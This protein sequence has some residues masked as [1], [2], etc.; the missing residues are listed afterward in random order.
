MTFLYLQ[1]VATSEY[2]IL[3]LFNG[4]KLRQVGFFHFAY[5]KV[6]FFYSL[7]YYASAVLGAPYYFWIYYC[8]RDVYSIDKGFIRF[9]YS[10]GFI[11]YAIPHFVYF[12]LLITSLKGE[13]IIS[14]DTI[15]ASHVNNVNGTEIITHDDYRVAFTYN[16][17]DWEICYLLFS[18][19]LIIVYLLSTLFL[20]LFYDDSFC[21]VIYT[22]QLYI[23]SICLY[24]PIFLILAIP[25]TLTCYVFTIN[26]KCIEFYFYYIQLFCH[27]VTIGGNKILGFEEYDRFQH[28]HNLWFFRTTYE[29]V[30][31][32]A[33]GGALENQR[34]YQGGLREAVRGEDV[35]TDFVLSNLH[36]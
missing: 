10:T 4:S 2:I 35:R 9:I 33:I 31:R 5:Y 24:L 17:N 32:F 16:I 34:R 23:F 13:S 7:V 20:L 15:E 3:N 1:F 22:S 14:D 19:C 11:F 28:P 36:D 6:Q 25:D 21:K 27:N 12:P 18:F 8:K 29:P 30:N 26:F